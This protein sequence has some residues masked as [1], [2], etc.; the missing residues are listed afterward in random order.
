[1]VFFLLFFLGWRGA[2]EFNSGVEVRVVG[3]CDGPG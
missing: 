1:M 2:V 3:W